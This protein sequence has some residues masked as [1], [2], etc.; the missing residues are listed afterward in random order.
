MQMLLRG[1][2]KELGDLRVKLLTQKAKKLQGKNKKKKRK[3]K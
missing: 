2:S 1:D 3:K